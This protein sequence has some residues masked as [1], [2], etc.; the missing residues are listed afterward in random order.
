MKKNTNLIW[1][2]WSDVTTAL[3]YC[4]IPGPL[5]DKLKELLL[6]ITIEEGY[7]SIEEAM[8]TNNRHQVFVEVF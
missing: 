6:K 5:S 8:A 3:Y 7:L 1:N 2:Y 4:G